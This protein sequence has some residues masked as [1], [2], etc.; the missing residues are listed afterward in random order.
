MLPETLQMK[1]MKKQK[2]SI[3]AKGYKSKSAA[4]RAVYTGKKMKTTGGLKKVSL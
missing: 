3:I 4:K 2:A 1:S